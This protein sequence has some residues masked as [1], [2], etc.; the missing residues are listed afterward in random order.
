MG[1]PCLEAVTDELTKAGVPFHVEQGGKHLRIQYGDQHQHL[2]VISAT[3]SDWR[4]PLNE[5][6]QIRKELRQ[7]GWLASG[8]EEQHRSEIVPVQIVDGEPACFSYDIAS[9][10]GK[11]H[12]DV[13]RAIDRIRDECGDEFDR[14]NFTPVEYLDQKGRSYRAFRMTRDGFSLVV[15]GFTGASATTWKVKYIAAFNSIANELAR[16]STVPAV[17]LAAIR[18]DID[19]LTGL[20]G[21]VEARLPVVVAPMPTPTARLSRHQFKRA[22][23]RFAWRVA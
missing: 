2:H 4:A 16:L 23:R 14:R 18:A 6:S 22:M 17:G 11:A 8:D 19:A 12:K 10:F 20:I 21:D 1:N 9:D 5:R 3:P 15:M 7:R 13:L